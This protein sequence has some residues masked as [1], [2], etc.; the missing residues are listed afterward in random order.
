MEELHKA[1]KVKDIGLSNF[2]IEQVQRVLDN[3][4]VAPTCHQIEVHV[5][6][7]NKELIHF[8]KSKNM[9]VVAYS[10]LGSGD[11]PKEGQFQY[12]LKFLKFPVN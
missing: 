1:G 11:R 6:L 8:S 2:N 5:N 3:S 7:Q 10:P 4:T 9:V 12:C